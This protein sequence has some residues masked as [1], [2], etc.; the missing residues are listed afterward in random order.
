MAD[1]ANQFARES[2]PEAMRQSPLERLLGLVNLHFDYASWLLYY[3]RQ[4]LMGAPNFS[5][6]GMSV[7]RAELE[8]VGLDCEELLSLLLGGDETSPWVRGTTSFDYC[9]EDDCERSAAPAEDIDAVR[10]VRLH[11]RAEVTAL[12][13]CSLHGAVRSL[14]AKLKCRYEDF[15][16]PHYGVPCED[17]TR[18]ARSLLNHE[19][20]PLLVASE[21]DVWRIRI[22]ERVRILAERYT[23]PAMAHDA[24]QLSTKELLAIFLPQNVL[25]LRQNDGR[26]QREVERR[27]VA[28]MVRRTCRTLKRWEDSGLAVNGI[29]WPKPC[30]TIRHNVLYFLPDCLPAIQRLAPR[31]RDP[32]R[33]RQLRDEI[34]GQK[35]VE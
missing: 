25:S 23:T 29:L 21:L 33:D 8:L 9:D 7:S 27:I 34:I 12:P 20:D 10:L 17:P 3:C 22:T 31:L 26:I 28:K 4:I 32:A 18:L 19:C 16:L 13:Y 11:L 5:L 2:P 6:N 24:I 30:R 15:L 14:C 1:C 35:Y